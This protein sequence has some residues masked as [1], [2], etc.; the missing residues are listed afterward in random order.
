[1]QNLKN[2]IPAIFGTIVILAILFY[3]PAKSNLDLLIK[4]V[5]I[6]ATVCY[7]LMNKKNAFVA[8]ET[9]FSQNGV[10]VLFDT[11]QIIIKSKVYD[12]KNIDAITVGSQK[13]LY[14]TSIFIHLDNFEKHEIAIQGQG[15]YKNF[16]Q[17]LKLALS[18]AGRSDLVITP[19]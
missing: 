15:E 5:L 1:M 4:L 6:A 8:D 16:I 17:R 13:L 11:K 2:Y 10:T 12:V 18:K 19:I 7:I 9:Q 3:M 14:T